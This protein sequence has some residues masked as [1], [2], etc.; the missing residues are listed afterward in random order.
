MEMIKDEDQLYE[1]RLAILPY[2][3]NG[4]C[5]ECNSPI[6]YNGEI[7]TVMIKDTEKWSIFAPLTLLKCPWCDCR[8][9][10]IAIWKDLDITAELAELEKDK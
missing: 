5:H 8:I 2:Y 9:K 3:E 10:S 6:E 7:L 4:I 1:N